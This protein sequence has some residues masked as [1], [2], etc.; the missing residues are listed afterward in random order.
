MFSE[1]IVSIINLLKL[2]KDAKKT[3]LEIER[4]ESEK[5]AR[6]SIIQIA[7]VEDIKKYDPKV[8]SLVNLLANGSPRY[9]RS[10]S[11]AQRLV[12]II[13][14]VAAVIWFLLR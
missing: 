9:S 6:E 14:L 7:S 4:L 3:D 2:R 12:A 13:F 10:G 5:K 1:A 8:R 11:S